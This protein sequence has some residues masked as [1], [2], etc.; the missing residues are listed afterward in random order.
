MREAPR[1]HLLSLLREG[2]EEEETGGAVEV[3][4]G[5]LVEEEGVGGVLEEF[6]GDVG[7]KGLSPLPTSNTFPLLLV[8]DITLHCYWS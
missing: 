4:G 7:G 1:A 6:H 8:L 2:G 3:V 5:R